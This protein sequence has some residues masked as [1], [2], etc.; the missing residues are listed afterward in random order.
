VRTDKRGCE[1]LIE[2]EIDV[3]VTGDGFCDIGRI[4]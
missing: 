1:L 4:C 2:I 3:T